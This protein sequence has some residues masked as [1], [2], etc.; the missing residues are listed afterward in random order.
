MA[1]L[2]RKPSSGSAEAQIRTPAA[3]LAVSFQ[4]LRLFRG[5]YQRATAVAASS[6]AT[7]SRTMRNA[8]YR[9][10]H[11]DVKAV[12]QLG[13]HIGAP[14]VAILNDD[15]SN[16]RLPSLPTPP[17]SPCT[18][19]PAPSIPTPAASDRAVVRKHRARHALNK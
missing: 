4:S 19:P 11:C 7:K 16:Q 8:L 10:V 2:K 15:C 12:L 18:P 9:K 5:K 13:K 1:L 14:C 17:L 3:I 6:P